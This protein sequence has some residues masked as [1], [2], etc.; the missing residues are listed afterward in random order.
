MD[1]AIQ[2]RTVCT[3]QLLIGENVLKEYKASGYTNLRQL[4]RSKKK[5]QKFIVIG[6]INGSGQIDSLIIVILSV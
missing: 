2:S 1:I 4:H 6:Q 3:N 5:H